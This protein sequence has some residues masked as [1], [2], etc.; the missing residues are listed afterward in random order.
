MFRPTLPRIALMALAITLPFPAVAN[1]TEDRSESPALTDVAAKRKAFLAS[2]TIAERKV[3]V[4]VAQ[5]WREDPE[6][7]DALRTLF[8]QPGTA[9]QTAAEVRALYRVDAV[10]AAAIE[11]LLGALGVT[12]KFVS[13][14]RPYATVELTAAQIQVLAESDDVTRI[15]AVIGPRAKGNASLAHDISSL[16]TGN[17]AGGGDLSG[18]GVVIGLISLPFSGSLLTALET[19]TAVPTEASGNLII[20][21]DAKVTC[22]P[23]A[24]PGPDPCTDLTADALNMLQVIHQIAPGAQVVIGSPGSASEP[25]EMATLIDAMVAGDTGNSVPAANIVFDDLYYPARTPLRSMRSQKPLPMRAL[26]AP[27]TLPQRAMADIMLR[28]T[29]TRLPASTLRTLRACQQ[30]ALPRRNWTLFLKRRT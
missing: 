9:S 6:T 25:G 2:R 24:D 19:A 22:D 18:S 8:G 16:S 13:Q 15:R 4:S 17:A 10:D 30:T 23:D 3:P 28:Q 26:L 12:P 5:Q 27:F 29:Q 7:F 21:G 14:R 11:T 1:T 20:L